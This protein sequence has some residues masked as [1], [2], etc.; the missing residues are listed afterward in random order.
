MPKDSN[1]DGSQPREPRQYRTLFVSDIHLGAR[2]CQADAFLD[3][4]RHNE[5]DTIY[6]A[7]DIIDF[8]SLKRTPLW[9]QSHNDVLQKLL[10]KARKGTRIV[11]IP[12][13]HDEAV[14][15]YCGMSFGAIEIHRDAV[16]VTADGRRFLVL[17]GDEFDV[18]VRYARWLALLGDRSY[19]FAVSC[20]LPLNFFRR[21]L[22]LGFW[23]LS[24]YLKL[25][26]KSAVNFIGEFEHAIAAEA[27]RRAADGVICG[28]IHHMTDRMIDGVRY[29]NCGDWVES[30]TAIAED[31][32]GTLHQI[33]WHSAA[34]KPALALPAPVPLA[35]IEALSTG[36]SALGVMT[37]NWAA[38]GPA[39]LANAAQPA[40]KDMAIAE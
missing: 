4:L 27:K 12:G 1:Q 16:H 31:H 29:V 15:S 24:N 19:E 3:F 8:W 22:G 2:A 20:N 39:P 32:D 11:F 28:H 13:N 23:S 36:A 7:G 26:V 25:R 10:R 30:C 38:A 34:A 21:R 35:A 18:V 9:L 6:L 17:H 33:H 37:A 5:A 40:R 14:R